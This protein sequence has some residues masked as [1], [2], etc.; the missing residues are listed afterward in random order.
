M[1]ELTEFEHLIFTDYSG[2]KHKVLSFSN[3]LMRW[4]DLR[5]LVVGWVLPSVQQLANLTK[6]SI[7]TLNRAFEKMVDAGYLIKKNGLCG[8][9]AHPTY[10]KTKIIDRADHFILDDACMKTGSL[11]QGLPKLFFKFEDKHTYS[12]HPKDQNSIYNPLILYLCGLLNKQHGTAYIPASVYYMHD[13][14]PMIRIVGSII[15]EE[16]GGIVIPRI[17]DNAVRSAFQSSKVNLYHVNVNDKGL[18]LVHLAKL[19]CSGKKIG[20]VYLMPV[21]NNPDTLTMDLEQIIEILKLHKKYKF[22][23]LIDD[24][25]RP[26]LENIG[27]LMLN[28]FSEV[29]DYIV[30]ISPISYLYEKLSRIN[31]VAASTLF[32]EKIRAAAK[33]QGKQ[34][35]YS[36]AFAVT[37]IL[38]STEYAQAVLNTNLAVKALKAIVYDVFT[39][40]GLWKPEGLRMNIGP[41][42]Y[43]VPKRGKFSMEHYEQLKKLGIYVVNPGCY[44]AGNKEVIG[45]RI[46]L[47]MQL[48]RQNLRGHFEKL[49]K[50]LAKMLV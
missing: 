23:L 45:F 27:H 18:D 26:W 12:V 46:E 6:L 25:M 37:S 9:I 22:M 50:L 13:Y 11:N 43:I 35:H 16:G 10:E 40:T 21:V 14:Q 17:I 8:V 3:D 38:Q 2:V 24:R 41:V 44:T 39:L 48:D 28:L 7:S 42:A 33:A 47:A 5:I 36:E 32:I 30:Y 4:V 15:G 19:C 34:A 31:M 1:R 20:A 49:E 29:S